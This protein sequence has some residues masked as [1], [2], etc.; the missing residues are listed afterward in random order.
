MNS[1]AVR[2]EERQVSNVDFSAGFFQYL[3]LCL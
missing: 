2:S 1:Q 3:G